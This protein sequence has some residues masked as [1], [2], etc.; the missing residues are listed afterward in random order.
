MKQN[1]E[2]FPSQSI[3]TQ[4]IAERITRE[5]QTALALHGSCSLVLAGGNT[6]REV[7]ARLAEPVYQ[8]RI[9]WQFVHLFWGDERAV[10]PDHSDSNYGMVYQ[11]L[12]KHIN[13]PPE[14][15]HRIPAEIAPE[16]AASLYAETLK[17]HFSNALPQFDVVLLGLGEDGHTASLFPGT[18]ALEEMNK[19]VTAVFVARLNTRRITLTFPVLNSARK[20]FFLVSGR[21]KSPKIQQIFSLEHPTKDLP[22]SL[23]SPQNGELTWMLD[24]DAAALLNHDNGLV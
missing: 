8:K 19:T 10:P 16:Q 13:I 5:I 17:Q 4:A 11:A 9:P 14:N 18:T 1:L 21:S 22:A 23:V 24:T 20:I 12:L 2:I 15:I 6:P 3:F 7:Y